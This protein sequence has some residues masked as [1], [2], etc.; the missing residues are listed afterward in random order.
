MVATIAHFSQPYVVGTLA[1]P[2]QTMLTSLSQQISDLSDEKDRMTAW[3][4]IEVLMEL[5]STTKGKFSAEVEQ[6]YTDFQALMNDPTNAGLIA[7]VKNDFQAL[8]Q[9]PPPPLPPSPATTFKQAMYDLVMKTMQEAEN[10]L[11][12][13][14]TAYFAELQ[15]IVNGLSAFGSTMGSNIAADCT[16]LQQKLSLYENLKTSDSQLSLIETLYGLASDINNII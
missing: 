8:S 13:D 11:P 5:S 1:S 3:G 2:W 4:E 6:L 14:S 15:G 9:L 7:T 10:P 12:K 16:Y